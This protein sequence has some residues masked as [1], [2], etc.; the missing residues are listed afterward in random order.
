M[1]YGTMKQ[2]DKQGG[3]WA[4]KGLVFGLLGVVL[5]I[6]LGF[7]AVYYSDELKDIANANNYGLIGMF[8][9][10]FIASSTFSVTPIA[11]PYWVVTLTLP[12]IMA[13]RY[14]IWSPVWVALVTATAASLGQF[15]TFMIGYG[16]RSLSEKL[17]HRFSP[18]IY[19][20]A[21]GWIRKTGSWA[22]FLMT[23][24][25][26]P[27]HLPMTIAIALLK[28]PPYKFLLYSFLGIGVRSFIIAFSGYYG[29]D[30]LNQLVAKYKTESFIS[31]P[32][33]IAVLVIAG[34]ILA[35]AVWQ[36]LIW[37]FEIR[38][39]S[40][41]Y[42]AALGCAKKS[43]KLL[44]V[45]G[46]PWG[47]KSFRRLLNKPAHGDGDICLDIDRRALGGHPCAVVASATDI[48][49][50][51]KTFGAVF[52]SH[53]MEHMPTTN[54]AKQALEEMSRVA[55]SIFIAYPSR[56]SIV[57]WIMRDHHIWIWQKRGKTYLKQRHDRAKKE[58]IVVE[59][60]NKDS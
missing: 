31:S 32:L 54:A 58:H 53:V 47:V 44:L 60:T 26:N 30:M 37:G 4:R 12:T 43:G 57:A 6:G 56:Q 59:T 14:G 51:D 13:P 50:S 35:I 24:I 28:Y 36:L 39:K 48:P 19:D 45:I 2:E 40:R 46:G 49:F 17:S 11:M 8:L 21:V 52:T 7:L 15:M 22:V 55:E 38:D 9:F 25:P 1:G 16:G 3:L 27:L 10:A 42:Q 20:R 5:T 34:I 33:S 18:Q 41:K 29:M 23:L